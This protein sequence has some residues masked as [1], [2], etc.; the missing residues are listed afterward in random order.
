MVMNAVQLAD[1][2]HLADACAQLLAAQWPAQGAT[3]RRSAFLAHC[4]GRA[5]QRSPLPC[6]VVLTD[7]TGQ[8]VLAHCRLQPACEN[9]D[10]FSAALTSVV[11]L[12]EL[13]GK[14]VGRRLLAEAESVAKE[15]GFAYMYLWTHDAQDFYA[16]CGYATCETVSL[17]RPALATI[18]TD[19]VKR[20]E[21]MLAKRSEAAAGAGGNQAVESVVR[22]DSVWM[23]KR[24]LE[25]CASVALSHEQL[26]QAVR[27]AIASRKGA[28]S[29]GE[30]ADAGMEATVAMEW[31]VKLAAFDWER[32]CGP[33]CGIAA[34]RMASSH[35]T[36]AGGGSVRSV[37]SALLHELLASGEASLELELTGATDQPAERSLL[38][39]WPA[40]HCCVCNVRNV[41]GT[42]GL[43]GDG[44]GT[45]TY[46]TLPIRWPIP[47]TPHPTLSH[48][49]TPFYPDPTPRV[50]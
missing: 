39:V 25:R 10:G 1:A 31:R 18:D 49:P 41:R 13:R 36:S 35:A 38:Q 8:E 34:L 28:V 16:K 50:S 33:C 26:V 30:D 2:P 40:G 19:A 37:G 23:R 29:S 21:Q 4:R 45:T 20:L 11:V 44:P 15:A 5:Q 27:D 48:P 17:L 32:Q 3:S 14:G 46:S 22:E 6:H 47:P 7:G 43:Q 12:P 9:A 24:L 42:G